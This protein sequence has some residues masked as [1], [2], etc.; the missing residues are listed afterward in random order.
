MS[1]IFLKW[2]MSHK[3]SDSV[4]P[5]TMGA[6]SHLVDPLLERASV[7]KPSQSVGGGQ[8]FDRLIH[9]A[10]SGET[11]IWLTSTFSSD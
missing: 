8:R 6:L 1:L 3:M 4:R 11:A 2:S 5:L 7:I 10:L 9:R